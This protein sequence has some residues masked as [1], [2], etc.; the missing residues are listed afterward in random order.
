[1]A[2]VQSAADLLALPLVLSAALILDNLQS[3]AVSKIR[4]RWPGLLPAVGTLV[5]PATVHGAFTAAV[6]K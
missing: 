5:A 6:K 2:N 3:K 1:M 4:G